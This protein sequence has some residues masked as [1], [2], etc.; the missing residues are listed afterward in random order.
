MLHRLSS[1]IFVLIAAMSNDA[2]AYRGDQ[3]YASPGKRADIG[4]GKLNLYCTGTGTPTVVLES[5]LGGRASAW[6][7]VQPVL[8]KTAT[9]C[10][11]DRAG[12]AF[13]DPGPQPRTADRLAADL[14][15]AL[16]QS[17]VPSPY[18]LVGTT[19]GAFVVRL[20]AAHSPSEVAGMVL[21][22]PSPEEEELTTASPTVARIDQQGLQHAMAC[23]DAA[24]RGTLERNGADAK[25][26]LPGINP[27]LSAQLNAARIAMLRKPAT[28]SALVSEWQAIRTS[29]AAVKAA[30]TRT[31]S[32]PLVVISAGHE[33][34]A[35]GTPVDKAA[36]HDAWRH[37]T[38]W[39][40]AIARISTDSL[41]VRT[42]DDSRTAET[43]DP[44][45]VIAAVQ[46]VIAAARNHGRLVR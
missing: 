45:L 18:I 42:K 30:S 43:T 14:H 7:R 40:D 16:A 10:S 38:A 23:R 27:E 24:A 31:F 22:N 29:A 2:R 36:L 5:G 44:S 6:A 17:K 34:E 28:W 37:W 25:D 26:C 32:F 12:Y 41:H 20:F 21:L 8:S 3:I 35:E 39:Q 46:K 9:V 13:S 33:P 19:F 11:Y 1:A 4:H 15:A